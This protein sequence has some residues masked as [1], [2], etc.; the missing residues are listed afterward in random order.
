MDGSR[1]EALFSVF[2]HDPEMGEI[3]ALFVEEMPDRIGELQSALDSMDLEAVQ[4]FAHQLKGAAGG[5]GFEQLGEIA[6]A[7]E[8]TLRSLGSN[9]ARIDHGALVAAVTPLLSAC[10]RVRLSIPHAAA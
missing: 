7:T 3:V 10:H 9:L 4:T 5:Y 8:R 1:E 2:E 6:A